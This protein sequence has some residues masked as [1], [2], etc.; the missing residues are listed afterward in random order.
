M[1]K[2]FLFLFLL[3][4]T[5]VAQNVQK[6]K[7]NYDKAVVFYQDNQIEKAEKV[8][9]FSLKFD[10]NFYLSYLLLAQIYEDKGDI[11]NAIIFYLKG[12][13]DNNPKNA[14]GYWKVG[15]LFFDQ[16][17]YQEAKVNFEHFLS[18]ENQREKYIWLS[19]LGLRNCNF[20]I[21]SMQNP[22]DFNPQNMG[23]E[24][25]SEFEEYLP[26]I[27]ADGKLFVITRRA[28]FIGNIVSEDFYVSFKN[29]TG[30]TKSVNMGT[31]IN[32]PG[33]EGAQCLSADGKILFF[34]A[35]DREDGF[36]R[37]D[38][39]ASFKTKNGWS[40]ARNLGRNI[41][42]S[43]WES[44]PSISPD[45]REL[46]F[47]SNRPGGIGKMDIWKST[48]SENGFF[49]KPENLGTQINT[50]FDEMSPFIHSDNQTF[51]FASNGHVGMGDFDLFLSRR[52]YPKS[53]W[54]FPENLGYPINTNEVENS[55]I[56]ASDGNTAYYAS[57]KFGYG[58]EDI[59]WFSLPQEKS[60]NK[61]GYLNTS[62][63]DAKSML[64][65]NSTIQLIDLSTGDVL[66][67]SYTTER[68]KGQKFT[69]LPANTNYA[70]N[71]SSDG[72]LFHSENFYLSDE[73]AQ[74][75]LNLEVLMNKIEIG[76][77]VVLK[78][79]FFDTDDYNLKE[80]ST[81]ELKKLIDFLINNPEI[82]IEIEGHTDDQ[83]SES[84]NLRLSENR[85]K[86]VYDF[87]ILNNINSSRLSYKGYGDSKPVSTNKTELG[88][89][90]NRRTA[91]TIK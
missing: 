14:W 84:H 39:Y 31:A 23:G 65:I 16:G 68:G 78:N 45:G 15:T 89:S 1:K 74:T 62:I 2:A 77:S 41:N 80:E 44:Q 22:V 88:R 58:Q 61:V 42:T 91:F 13:A 54:G 33:N 29:D 27:S 49:G 6:A 46:Y 20:A 37:C 26:S 72:Y 63:K 75:A 55:L 79:I 69:S 40:K 7:K 67:E 9:L 83:G 12:L 17:K 64:P 18:F 30:W 50:E 24:I 70:L 11:D 25:N 66:M 19:N 21:K 60:A 34:T 43:S 36:G 35:C 52:K 28:P 5:L 86:S 59:F 32:S 8:A 76:N 51:Y 4:F 82:N 56:V 3:P 87:L 10:E 90:K 53:R 73:S 71:V 48:L 81:V 57:D 38:I 47:V 85:S